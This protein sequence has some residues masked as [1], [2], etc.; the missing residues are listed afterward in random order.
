MN[1]ISVIFILVLA[2]LQGR[3]EIV[4]LETASRGEISCRNLYKFGLKKNAKV[5]ILKN[6]VV[7][8]IDTDQLEPFGLTSHDNIPTMK[9]NMTLRFQRSFCDIGLLNSV[10][11]GRNGQIVLRCSM[12]KPDPS[13][14]FTDP[15]NFNKN[16]VYL[17]GAV[18]QIDSVMTE[19]NTTINGSQAFVTGSDAHTRITIS[20]II[21]SEPYGG[22]GFYTRGLKFLRP[23]TAS[24]EEIRSLP[25][26]KF[27]KLAN[28]HADGCTQ[29]VEPLE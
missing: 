8:T 15:E 7:V 22:G 20:T 4:K 16:G 29:R 13:V 19:M 23:A 6:D 12:N 17:N 10:R 3:A 14:I 27:K 24:E 21:G 25:E 28:D 1:K 9:K 5:E 11:L 2:S 18:L 26:R